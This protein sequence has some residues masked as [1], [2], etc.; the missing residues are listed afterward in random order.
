MWI[1]ILQSKISKIKNLL[2]VPYTNLAKIILRKFNSTQQH[3]IK[4]TVLL[5]TQLNHR[6]EKRLPCLVCNS[7]N[8]SPSLMLFPCGIM[9]IAWEAIT[10]FRCFTYDYFARSWY[11]VTVEATYYKCV[12]GFFSFVKLF[13]HIN[14]TSLEACWPGT[15][16]RW[17]TA[18]LI[19][20]VLYAHV[21]QQNNKS[22][23]HTTTF[24][25]AM[26]KHYWL[27]YNCNDTSS[28]RTTARPVLAQYANTFRTKAFPELFVENC[29]QLKSLFFFLL[30]F[31]SHTKPCS[32]AGLNGEQNFLS[33]SPQF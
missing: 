6:D 8:W 24:F 1:I 31:T 9:Y 5:P 22:F 32:V 23:S 11:R 25:F 17:S 13:Q 4:T 33:M 15:V 2:S 27:M 3:I 10:R 21:Q 26:A 30:S 28:F 12:C 29:L 20:R 19:C 18:L 7:D 16:N 14:Q